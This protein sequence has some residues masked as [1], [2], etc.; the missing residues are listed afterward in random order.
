MAEPDKPARVK[1]RPGPPPRRDWQAVFLE[2]IEKNVVVGLACKRAGVSEATVSREKQRNQQF[3]VAYHETRESGLDA[4]EAVLR[5]RAT[6][7]QPMRKRVTKF[8]KDGNVREVT[9][10]EELHVSDTLGMFLLKRYRPE[11]RESYRVESSRSERPVRD[12]VRVDAA[13]SDF[14]DELD[15][16]ASTDSTARG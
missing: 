3:A 7:G 10:T 15:R 2:E 16:L 5:M 8:D 4:L 12:E 14:Y 9:E 1:K 6:S 13:L 11:F